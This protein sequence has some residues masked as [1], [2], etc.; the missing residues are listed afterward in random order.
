MR[1]CSLLPSSTEI[2]FALG[3]GD[4]L[5]GVTHE[6][7]FPEEASAK[8]A[9][10][11]SI[12]DH[13]ASSE[14]EIH[15]HVSDAVHGGSSI[16]SLDQALLESID[17]DVVLTQELCDVC[18]VSY[19][20][21]QRAVRLLPNER[22]VLSLEPTSLNGILETI[23]SVS[24]VAGVSDRAVDV[25]ASL[26]QRIDAVAAAAQSVNRRP[27]VFA[28]EWLDPPF[29][30]GHWVPEMIRLAGGTDGL[31]RE[32]HPSTQVTWQDIAGYDPEVIVLMPCGYHLE[33]NMASFGETTMPAEWEGLAAVRNGEVYAV[34]GSSYYN[35]PGPRAVGGL[36]IMAEI[37][38]P[39]LF[40]RTHPESDWRRVG[41]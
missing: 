32:G 30:G 37:L 18:A 24:E 5:V 34:D 1:I 17:P 29:I 16:Y 33:E 20:E 2:V 27:R 21:V 7:D 36:E 28:M 40:P 15:R 38:H 31:G 4:S 9:V 25:V 41:A 11:S 19:G 39:E 8:P 12:I 23:S 35:R 13:S 22:K 10:T 3:L 26:R 14:A 6:C